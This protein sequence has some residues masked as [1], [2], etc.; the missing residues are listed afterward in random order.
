MPAQTIDDVLARLQAI[1][2]DGIA[3]NNRNGYFAALYYK[4]TA[5]VKEG[6]ANGR[7]ENGARMEQFDVIFASRYLDA[8]SAWQNK[9]PLSA[10]WQVAFEA[11]Q[12]SSLLVL[13]HLLLGM[14]AHINLDLGIA[15]AQVSGGNLDT[16]RNDFDDINTIISALT[17]QVLNDIDQVSPLLSLLGLHAGNQA[18][19]L[20]QFSIDNARDGAW[21]FAE[22]LVTKQ[23]A[24]YTDCINQRDETIK[25]LAL[26][27]A[28]TTGF[29]RFTIWFIHLFEWKNVSRIIK[30]MHG[31]VKKKIVVSKQGLAGQVQ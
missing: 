9:Q 15:A 13:Q 26:D 11:A 24:A 28:N 2:A 7:F 6:V 10:S 27:L 25:K 31:Q 8:L 19:I 23:G 20:I 17:Y 3:H 16:V 21:C 29:V 5:S 12:N 18:S 30:V 4:V 14:N 1:I 22:D